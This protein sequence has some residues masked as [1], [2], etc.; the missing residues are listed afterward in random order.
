MDYIFQFLA[1]PLKWF[2]Q[3]TGSFTVGVLLYALLVEVLMLPLAIKQQ[4]NSIRQAKLAPKE[5][6][7]KRKY[8]GREDQPT[9][10]KCMQE[11]QEMYQR[12]NF[13]QLSGCLPL[14]IQLPIVL[15]IYNIVVDPLKYV[16]GLSAGQISVVQGIANSIGATSAS[17]YGGNIFYIST[18]FE[19]W[20]SLGSA[21][22]AWLQG[23]LGN[24]NLGY[25]RMFGLNMGAV[26]S[27]GKFS[28]YWL[29]PVLTFVVY[30]GSMKLTRKFTY[31]SAA[32]TDQATGCSN[33]IM[34]IMMPLF[35]VYIAFQVPAVISVY[36]IFK[37]LLGTVK[38]FLMQKAM[39]IPRFTEADYR[40]A[41]K[42]MKAQKSGRAAMPAPG[43]SGPAP[44]SLHHIDDEDYD[45]TREK[46]QRW[47]EKQETLAREAEAKKEAEEKA[48]GKL[49]G[50]APIASGTMKTDNKPKQSNNKKKK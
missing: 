25:F 12:E 26:A 8:A 17:Q 34:D 48:S 49:S 18:L 6:A 21:A 45:D 9:K 47:K 13:N 35:S 2:S 46:A 40:A 23:A 1:Y 28:I 41:E 16:F 14:V 38:Q 11:I 5:M 3:W 4:K 30:F 37:S 24:C 15:I 31:Q 36:W 29:L 32:A 19:N 33:N 50:D 43:L 22:Q 20:D 7:I 39:P 27:I 44:R 42:E 10:Q